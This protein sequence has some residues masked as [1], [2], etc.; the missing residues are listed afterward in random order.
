[1]AACKTR[2]G[3]VG[4]VHACA[5][6]SAEN[7]HPSAP[8]PCCRLSGEGHPEG[9]G[10]LATKSLAFY[11]LPWAC[12]PLVKGLVQPGTRR[13]CFCRCWAPRRQSRQGSSGQF[14]WDTSAS[15]PAWTRPHGPHRG[16]G[17]T[18]GGCTVADTES[19]V[20]WSSVWS[21]SWSPESKYLR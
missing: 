7:L 1:M 8:R 20:I 11:W 9:A 13:G 18:L 16:G 15:S 3:L 21:R 14:H 12:L 6:A 17:G 4:V 19:T 2:G 10:C 5:H